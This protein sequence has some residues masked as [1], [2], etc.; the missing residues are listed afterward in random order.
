MFGMRSG[1]RVLWDD[2]VGSCVRRK[3]TYR[4][5]KGKKGR[6]IGIEKRGGR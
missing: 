2:E 3:I 5:G 4:G 1:R 6:G